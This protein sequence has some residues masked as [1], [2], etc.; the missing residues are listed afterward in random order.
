MG[1]FESIP[2][3]PANVAKPAMGFDHHGFNAAIRV[4]T[5]LK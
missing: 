3:I 4:T 2:E 5:A 1:G